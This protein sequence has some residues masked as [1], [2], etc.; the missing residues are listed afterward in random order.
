MRLRQFLLLLCMGVGSCALAD[1]VTNETVLLLHGL[2]RS[3]RSMFLMERALSKEGYDVVRLEYPSTKYKV[4]KLTEKYLAPE[5]EK[6]RNKD[7]ARIH[8]VAHSLGNIMLRYY[9]SDHAIPDNMGCIV[10][11][12]PPN[13]GSEVVDKIGHMKPFD[14][15]NGP[16][17][18]QLGTSSNSLPNQLPVP[19]AEIGVIAGT[20]SVNWIL[21]TYIPGPDDGKVSPENAKIEGMKDFAVVPATHTFMMNKPEV[22]K[23]TINFLKHGR[24]NP[25]EDEQAEDG[26]LRTNTTPQ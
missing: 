21:S 7:V 5:I 2:A 17:G 16:A 10:M 9:F 14:W 24:F 8:F 3:G 20:R 25:Q 19:D 4:E 1:N 23:M 22:I 15:V 12:G 26:D 18:Q 11:L 6:V 13:K